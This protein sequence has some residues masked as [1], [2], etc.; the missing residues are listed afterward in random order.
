MPA[1]R[2]SGSGRLRAPSAQVRWKPRSSSSPPEAGSPADTIPFG[3]LNTG[4]GHGEVGEERVGEAFAEE[5]ELPVR[6]PED[7]V[8]LAGGE[9]GVDADVAAALGAEAGVADVHED[10]APGPSRTCRR[11][12]A[13]G[14][15]V[16]LYSVYSRQVVGTDYTSG[17]ARSRSHHGPW[18]MTWGRLEELSDA[19][20]L[21][22]SIPSCSG[23]SCTEYLPL[24]GPSVVEPA[25]RLCPAGHGDRHR[26]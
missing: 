14:W 16:P 22:S 19:P 11:S 26:R 12:P 15:N 20:A 2:P 7:V 13:A 8:A 21:S 4:F 6:A 17:Q 3:S 5:E 23:V 1:F 25:D 9:G 18:A 10:S 24:R